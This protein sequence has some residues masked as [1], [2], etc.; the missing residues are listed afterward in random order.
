MYEIHNNKAVCCHV[1]YCIVVI[2]S[3]DPNIT[4]LLQRKQP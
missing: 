1:L 3:A 2:V 4:D